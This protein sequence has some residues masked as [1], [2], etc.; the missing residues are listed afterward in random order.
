MCS[1]SGP[2]SVV[3]RW[4]LNE[5]PLIPSADPNLSV[6][7]DGTLTVTAPGEEYS[8]EYVCNVTTS[9]S[10][11]FTRIVVFVGSKSVSVRAKLRRK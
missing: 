9:Y 6:S 8:G 10:F 1:F 4:S 5:I 2:P 11:D 3:Q 7:P